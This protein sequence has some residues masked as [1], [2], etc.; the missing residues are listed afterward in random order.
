MQAASETPASGVGSP[1]AAA[2]G[3]GQTGQGGSGPG[4]STSSNVSKPGFG[5]VSGGTTTGNAPLGA[6]SSAVNGG[7]DDG[8]PGEVKRGKAI[9]ALGSI[10]A[11]AGKVAAGTVGNL[12]VGSWDVAKDKVGDMKTSTLD[13]IGESTG[14]KIAAAIDARKA[15][16]KAVLFGADSLAAADGLTDRESEVAAFRNRS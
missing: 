3:E 10:A 7:K 12:A 13:R 6:Q 15:A 2:M 9:K 1:L 11:K 5:S 14:G 4:T 16:D 8:A